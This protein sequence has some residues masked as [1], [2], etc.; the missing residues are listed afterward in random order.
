MVKRILERHGRYDVGVYQVGIDEEMRGAA[1]RFAREIILSDNQYSRLLPENVRS[2]NDA[3]EQQ[4]I[5]I[6]RTYIGKLGE[7]VFWKLLKSLGKTVDI[8]GMF[9]VYEGQDNVDL[10]DFKTAAGRSV[11]VK[12]G[13]RD[14]HTRL[15]VNIEQFDHIPKDYYVGVKLNAKDTNASQKLVDWD[16][17]TI[18]TVKGYAEHSYMRAHAEVRDFGEG[19]ARWLPYNNLLGIDRLIDMF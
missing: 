6:Q 17:I 1:Q 14:K 5:E 11:D 3:G 12:T 19:P 10:F 4:K 16:S 18:A 9:E 8:Q 13:F 15:L 2:A 7:I